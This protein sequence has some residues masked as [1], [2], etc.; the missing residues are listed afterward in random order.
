MHNSSIAILIPCYNEALTIARVVTDFRRTLPTATIYVFDNNSSDGT[1][2]AARDAG[3]IVRHVSRQG[4]G[5]VVRRMFADVEA[6]IYVLV[7]GDATYDAGSAPALIDTLVTQHLDMVVGARVHNS[8]DAYRPGHQLGNRLLTRATTLIF[9]E[10]FTDMLSGYRVFSRRFVKSFPAMSHGFETETE[11]TIHAL[12]L[13]MPCAELA[14]PYGARPDGSSS[15]LNTYADGLRILTTII[16]LFAIERPLQFYSI[17][18]VTLS[19]V[20][21]ALGVPLLDTYL[22]TGLVPRF[23]TAI[24]CTGLMLLSAIAFVTGLIQEA[25]SV[26]RREAKQFQYLSAG[27]PFI[28]C[29]EQPGQVVN[30]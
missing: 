26:G 22:K 10:C 9:G 29:R 14:T 30:S 4:K 2:H 5:N 16:K 27:V 3:A 11:L 6:D 13:R 20:A 18:A 17:L 24:L 28:Q 25:I 1:A 12:E 21:V 23:P 8:S 7:D 19:L 15:K